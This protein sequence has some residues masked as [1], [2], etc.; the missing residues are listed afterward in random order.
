MKLNYGNI[1]CCR[2]DHAR[3]EP[4]NSQTYEEF[5]NKYRDCAL[6]AHYDEKTVS[7]I[8]DLILS[9]E[10]TEDVSELTILMRRILNLAR[11]TPFN[12]EK[13]G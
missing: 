3:G 8:K 4:Q 10:N 13:Q 12:K 1:Y 9:L 7:R 11:S 5:E 6:Y 2:V